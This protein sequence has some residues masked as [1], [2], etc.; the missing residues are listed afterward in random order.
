MNKQTFLVEI[1]TEELPQKILHNLSKNFC[2]HLVS[3]IKKLKIMHGNVEI[4]A[5]SRRLAIKIFKLHEY[6]LDQNIKKIGPY[7]SSIFDLNK[8]IPKPAEIWA[9]KN[10]IDILK[11]KFLE[12][13]NGYSLIYYQKIKGKLTKILLP[14]IIKK[15]L[16]KISAPYSMKW[17]MDITPFVRP[18]RTITVLLDNELINMKLFNIQSN[19]YINGHRFL[20]KN[21]LFLNHANEYPSILYKNNQIIADFN[22]RKEKI[23]K[24]IKS[25][26]RKLG[27][28]IKFNSALL[29]EINSLVESPNIYYGSFDKKF[30]IIPQ[31]ILIYIMEVK[32]KCFPIYDINHNLLKSFIFVANIKSKSST[33]IVADYEKILYSHF[34]DIL[35]FITQDMKINFADRLLKLKQIIFQKDLGNMYDKTKRIKKLSIW[36]ANTLNID[37]KLIK[38]T[39]LLSKCDLVTQLVNEHPDLQ[40]IVGMYYAL[41]NGE[42]KEIAIALKEQYLPRF[43]ND[44]LPSNIIGSILSIAEKIDVITGIMIL[45]KISKGNSDP[46][47]LRR[48]GLGLLKI[49]VHNRFHIDL[50]NLVE[51]SIECYNQL[52]QTKKE[53]IIDFL[54]KRLLS[55]Y[56]D[57]KYNSNVIKSILIFRP[58][59][60]MNFDAKVKA[61]TLFYNSKQINALLDLNKRIINVFSKIN[62]N[63]VLPDKINV[64]YLVEHDEIKLFQVINQIN[65]IIDHLIEQNNYESLLNETMSLIKPVNNFFKNVKINVTNKKLYKN[66]LLILK[67][68]KE[69]FLKIADFSFLKNSEL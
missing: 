2:N 54:L 11:T 12:R 32:Q 60:P 8:K 26:A 66:R 43:S 67:N 30:L 64:K 13:N 14:E 59:K 37:D 23:K 42:K 22:E 21:K 6:Q 4:F 68:I 62:K 48:A 38:R 53:I 69:I 51:K 17:H 65:N 10:K 34:S 5:T 15:T 58:T 29:N 52:Q 28:I 41:N 9:F 57:K 61:I 44:I 3:E 39:A 16:E 27:G 33:I 56:K 1:G 36:I 49:I 31:E 45:G 47:G 7:F 25:T 18:I 20:G 24:D 40:G 55:W 35:F 46:F 19:R 50:N 63:V